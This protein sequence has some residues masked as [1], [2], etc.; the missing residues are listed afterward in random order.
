MVRQMLEIVHLAGYEKRHIQTLSGG[1]KQR[2]AIGRAL[3]QNPVVLLLDEPFSGLDI[4]L[5]HALGREFRE[6]R[7]NSAAP[8]IF[9]THSPEEALA[10]GDRIALINAGSIVE[11]GSAQELARNPQTDFGKQFFTSVA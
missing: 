11:I 3:A 4:V 7:K 2:L 10:L 9:V 6:I 8:W 5:R 1:E